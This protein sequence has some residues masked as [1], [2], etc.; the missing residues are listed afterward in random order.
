MLPVRPLM[1]A[2]ASLR[3]DRKIVIRNLNLHKNGGVFDHTRASLRIDRKIV[4]RSLNLHKNGHAFDHK[5][6]SQ[7][8]ITIRY[9]MQPHF[10]GDHLGLDGFSGCARPHFAG[11]HLGLDGFSG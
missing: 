9:C 8:A 11:N 7:P 6:S 2:E 5:L 3:I 4:F 1:A 10:A